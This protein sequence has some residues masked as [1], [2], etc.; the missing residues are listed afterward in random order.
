MK[1]QK[2][3]NKEALEGVM[4]HMRRLVSRPGQIVFYLT[5][6]ITKFFIDRSISQD[7]IQPRN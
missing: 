6:A 7:Y 5:T 2:R 4:R 3:K 1:K